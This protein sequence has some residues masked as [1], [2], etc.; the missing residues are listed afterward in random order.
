MLRFWSLQR[1]RL[2]RVIVVLVLTVVLLQ[3]IHM[4]L[5][6]RLEAQEGAQHGRTAGGTAAGVPVG[7]QLQGRTV[8]NVIAEMHER[9]ANSYRLDKSGTYHIID[10]FLTSEHV[11]LENAHDVTIVTQCTAN[12]LHHLI[13]LSERWKGPVAVAVFTFDDDFNHAIDSILYHHF[14]SDSV[15]KYVTFHLVFPISRT[16][17]DLAGAAKAAETRLSCS[18]P[19]VSPSSQQQGQAKNYALEG[20]EYP[21]NVLRNLAVN[22]VQTR[23]VFVVDVD[24]LPSEDLRVQFQKLLARSESENRTAT[25]TAYVVPSFEV[26]QGVALPSNKGE[27]LRTWETWSARPFYSEL[28]AKCQRPTDFERWK[29]LS[30]GKELRIGYTLEWTDPWEP[31]YITKASLPLYDERFKQ[32]GFNRI[33]QVCEMHVAGYNFAVLNNAFLLHKGFKSQTSFHPT[34][35][36][37]QN[38]NRLLFR[39]FKEELKTKYPDSSRRC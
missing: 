33:S 18:H 2:G 8:K 36:E 16:P 34:K 23:Y 30:K 39:K 26:K 11:V 9:V 7:R 32:Y 15:F 20:I 22:Y 14:C 28:C 19:P 21:H 17:R 12:H 10:N 38:R 25:K 29:G 5:L 3:L 31:F 4:M 13:E 24:M 1:F 6:T 35:E 27:L 37:E